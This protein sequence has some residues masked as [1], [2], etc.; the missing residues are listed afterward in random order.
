MRY[1]PWH[2]PVFEVET[3]PESIS[4]RL[5]SPSGQPQWDNAG[6]EGSVGK[7]EMSDGSKLA[8]ICKSRIK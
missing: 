6:I 8:P 4:K 1:E 2:H 3:L 7:G 5:D